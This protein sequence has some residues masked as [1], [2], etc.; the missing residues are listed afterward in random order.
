MRAGINRPTGRFAAQSQ[1]GTE[2]EIEFESGSRLAPHNDSAPVN[3][4]VHRAHAPT[5]SGPAS[6]YLGEPL[7][8]S[9]H[10]SLTLGVPPT[11]S[12]RARHRSC[13][14]SWLTGI[15]V[16]GVRTRAART[17]SNDSGHRPAAGIE[18]APD[19][20]RAYCRCHCRYGPFGSQRQ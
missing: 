20:D 16:V 5:T 7:R 6:T 12:M 2:F 19:I 9:L 18:K 3:V 1:F 10:T 11:T 17:S 15:D 14:V 8:G 4:T 13:A